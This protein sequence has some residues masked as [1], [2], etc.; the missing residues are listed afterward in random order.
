VPVSSVAVSVVDFLISLV[1]L[2]AL[3]VV[4]QVAPGWKVLFLPV[5]LLLAVFTTL[6]VAILFSA[7]NVR[8]RDFRYVVGFI[9][10]FGL[11]VSPVGFSSAIVPEQ[12]RSLYALNPMVGIIEGFRWCLAEAARPPD[13]LAL[14]LSLVVSGALLALGVAY[15]RR[16]ERTFADVI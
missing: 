7:L 14:L 12:W 1:V 5:F 9:V 6:G 8:Y 13:P 10:Q 16:T 11:F 2:A 4:Y 3:M 15:F